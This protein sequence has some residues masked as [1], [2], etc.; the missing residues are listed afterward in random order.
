MGGRIRDLAGCRP[1]RGCVGVTSTQTTTSV[2][3]GCRVRA[4]VRADRKSGGWRVENPRR[5]GVNRSCRGA[6]GSADRKN[7]RPG[8]DA[9]PGRDAEDAKTYTMR[10]APMASV[11]RSSLLGK[12]GRLLPSPRASEE[13]I[14][15]FLTQARPR[16][17]VF[18]GTSQ[19]GRVNSTV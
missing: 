9:T 16:P 6:R 4:L 7:P 8:L 11:L 3:S 18:C 1:R 10:Y 14:S 15:P 12:L 5:G 13:I 19:H 17:A 2:S